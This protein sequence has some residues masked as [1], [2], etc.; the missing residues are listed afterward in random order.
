M[1]PTMTATMLFFF[2]PLDPK[3]LGS[4]VRAADTSEAMDSSSLPLEY[5]V[6]EAHQAGARMARTTIE[7]GA[8]VYHHPLKFKVS[9][10]CLYFTC[11]HDNN[12]KNWFMIREQNIGEQVIGFSSLC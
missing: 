6:E 3:W 8:K 10:P 2:S 7:A 12:V 9:E 5:R 4:V 11:D 1:N